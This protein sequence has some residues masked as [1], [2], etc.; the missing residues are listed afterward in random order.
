MTQAELLIVKIRELFD[1]L[2]LEIDTLT[3]TRTPA[4]DVDMR[5]AQ[6]RD[7]PGGTLNSRG[8]SEMYRLFEAG[9]TSLEIAMAMGVSLSGVSKRRTLWKRSGGKLAAKASGKA[10]ERVGQLA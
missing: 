1:R 8:I 6:Y 2:A 7:L 9:L 4:D 10:T 3:K 5:S